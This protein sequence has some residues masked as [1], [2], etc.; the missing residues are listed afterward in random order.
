MVAILF[1]L[2]VVVVIVV[3]GSGERDDIDP[4]DRYWADCGKIINDI[5][6]QKQKQRELAKI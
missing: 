2:A 1:W 4:E 6:R 3:L 5:N